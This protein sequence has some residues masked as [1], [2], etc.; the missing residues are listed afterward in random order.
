VPTSSASNCCGLS[1][2][3]SKGCESDDPVKGRALN[4]SNLF[5]LYIKSHVLCL[6]RIMYPVCKT[7]TAGALVLGD[8]CISTLLIS[9]PLSQL[10][11]LH[12]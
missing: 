5:S 11:K 2:L 3:G 9:G 8:C 4:L 10:H 1:G 6:P 7:C 12:I